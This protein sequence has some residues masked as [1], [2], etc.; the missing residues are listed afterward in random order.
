MG[1][2]INDKIY[3]KKV[4]KL[5][6]YIKTRL[7]N[8]SLKEFKE[9][10]PRDRGN[11]RRNTILSKRPDEFIIKGDYDYSG[12]LDKGLFPNP[13]VAG[14]GKTRNGYSTQ[15]PKGMVEPTLKFI[16]KEIKEFIKR[17]T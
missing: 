17:N 3:R 5:Q 6:R 15:A 1:M 16:E 4:K 13:P 2:K 9:N 7:P 8:T 10:T 12:V 14:T 11:A